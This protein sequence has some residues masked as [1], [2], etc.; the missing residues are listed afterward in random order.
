MDA[1]AEAI[2]RSTQF[3]GPLH[4]EEEV[5]KI[6]T[7]LLGALKTGTLTNH[8]LRT[9]A[10]CIETGCRKGTPLKAV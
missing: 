7:E 6:A 1:I 5:R 3:R 2:M 9:I 8:D 4:H 10:D